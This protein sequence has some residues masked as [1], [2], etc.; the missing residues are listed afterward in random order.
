MSTWKSFLSSGCSPRGSFFNVDLGSLH[1]WSL[2]DIIHLEGCC[3]FSAGTMGHG[4]N[5]I[6]T[7]YLAML[8]SPPC[9]VPSSPLGKLNCIVNAV[10]SCNSRQKHSWREKGTHSSYLPWPLGPHLSQPFLLLIS[11]PWNTTYLLGK[12]S[13]SQPPPRICPLLHPALYSLQFRTAPLLGGTRR[14]LS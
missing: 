4:W 13:S 2:P 12:E 8:P 10:F 6:L 11:K 5:E 7:W 14:E 9:S 1:C 3:P